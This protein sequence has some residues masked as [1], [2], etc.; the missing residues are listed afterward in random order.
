MV[1]R[2]AL[3][4]MDHNANTDREQVCKQTQNWTNNKSSVELQRQTAGGLPRFDLVKQRHGKK[5]YVKAV[6]VPKDYNWRNTL[7][8]LTV[9]VGS[10][11]LCVFVFTF[12]PLFQYVRTGTRPV[13]KI[14]LGEDTP[15]VKKVVPKPDKADAIKM[16]QSRFKMD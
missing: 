14:P 13:V 15:N 3:A 6:K 10:P 11:C 1:I 2:A 4:A 16:H 7:A 5:Y 12:E 9:K 8:S